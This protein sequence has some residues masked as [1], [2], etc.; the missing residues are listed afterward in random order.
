MLDVRWARNPPVD[1]SPSEAG[2][3]GV[4]RPVHGRMGVGVLLALVLALRGR[5]RWRPVARVPGPR[6]WP[7]RLSG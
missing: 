1:T 6:R 5:L 3:R 4:T 2:R 7:Q